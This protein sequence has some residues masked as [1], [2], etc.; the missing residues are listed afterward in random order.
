M[1]LFSP[2]QGTWF[3]CTVTENESE[4]WFCQRP[5]WAGLGSD[6]WESCEGLEAFKTRITLSTRNGEVARTE[7]TKG[8]EG[9]EG[10]DG[11]KKEREESTKATK[12][13]GLMLGASPRIP[14]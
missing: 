4:N 5:S 3:A 7:V 10:A 8:T 12:A 6:P 11:M 14:R 2:S 9:V 1:T 13:N